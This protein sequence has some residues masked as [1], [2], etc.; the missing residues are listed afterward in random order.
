MRLLHRRATLMNELDLFAALP[1]FWQSAAYAHQHMTVVRPNSEVRGVAEPLCPRL[2]VPGGQAYQQKKDKWDR[3]D[4]HTSVD[5][6]PPNWG[7][8]RHVEQS[9]LNSIGTWAPGSNHANRMSWRTL[10]A[11]TIGVLLQNLLRLMVQRP[12]GKPVGPG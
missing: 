9:V 8:R 1:S 6:G 3:V 12:Q 2:A 4:Q 10:V 5:G 7:S 11:L